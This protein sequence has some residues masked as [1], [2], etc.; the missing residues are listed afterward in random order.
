MSDKST[1]ALVRDSWVDEACPPREV[2]IDYLKDRLPNSTEQNLI[3]H[4]EECGACQREL[5]LLS[6]DSFTQQSLPVIAGFRLAA[7]LGRGGMGTVYLAERI[8]DSGVVAIKVLPAEYG[9][10]KDRQ[11]RFEREIAAL[12]RLSHPNIV[13]VF[14]SGICGESHYFVMEYL[15]GVTLAQF[16]RSVPMAPNVAIRIM[17]RVVGAVQ[18]AHAHQ[19]VHRDLKPANIVLTPKVDG[20]ITV[21]RDEMERCYD[22]KLVD[23]GLAKGIEQASE[24]THLGEI[25]GTIGYMAPEQV[26]GGKVGPA[27]DI[28]AC[29]VLLYELLTGHIPHQAASLPELIDQIRTNEPIS[30]RALVPGISTDLETVCHKCLEKDPLR[31]YRSATELAADL[32]ACLKSQKISA[33][34]VSTARRLGRWV[35]RHPTTTSMLVS[36]VLLLAVGFAVTIWMLRQSQWSY[37]AL[38]EEQRRTLLESQKVT[39]LNEV[40]QEESRR[41]QKLNGRL[42]DQLYY[43]HSPAATVGILK[44]MTEAADQDARRN[45]EARNLWIAYQSYRNLLQEYQS[46]DLRQKVAEDGSLPADS[47]LEDIV[48]VYRA[49]LEFL[50]RYYQITSVLDLAAANSS[51]VE[52]ITEDSKNEQERL[53][54]ERPVLVAE[55]HVI[56]A[57]N[58]RLRDQSPQAIEFY[59]AAL[60]LYSNLDW[61]GQASYFQTRTKLAEVLAQ[62][63]RLR[64][65]MRC[66]QLGIGNYQTPEINYQFKE[67]IKELQDVLYDQLNIEERRDD[68]FYAI[69]CQGLELMAGTLLAADTPQAADYLR[70]L[71]PVW[72]DAPGCWEHTPDRL[73]ATLGGLCEQ[74]EDPRDRRLLVDCLRRNLQADKR[75]RPQVQA[76]LNSELFNRLVQLPELQSAIQA[77]RNPRAKRIPAFF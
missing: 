47:S 31:R 30:I 9:Q 6:G 36:S 14:E 29:G 5:D 40:L 22:L 27:A 49:A 74:S 55:L 11:K 43:P 13:Q 38:A 16:S 20:P 25:V 56:M 26:M 1:G 65:Q 44:E 15:S 75:A 35:Q 7:E 76:V 12:S 54:N 73:L 68:G 52:G 24:L 70:A 8:L 63:S 21:G 64:S 32:D 62:N 60:Q 10:D 37:L 67:N 48:K 3:A 23:F 28:Y 72:M 34:P 4:V 71:I 57:N 39:S 18:H 19:V 17:C 77:A 59:D 46:P 2:L 66:I 53:P 33:R 41:I 51:T 45:P 58:H 69:N 42:L 61:D 50:E